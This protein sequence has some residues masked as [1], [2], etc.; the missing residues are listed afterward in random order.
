MS[1]RGKGGKVRLRAFCEIDRADNCFFCFVLIDRHR[2]VLVRALFAFAIL[3]GSW[4][5]WS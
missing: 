4:K 3:S 5:G 1:G 2:R